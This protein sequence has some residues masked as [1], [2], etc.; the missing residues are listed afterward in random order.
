[1]NNF[2]WTE[3]QDF[4]L[5]RLVA[6]GRKFNVEI[7]KL[8]GK[9]PASITWRIKKLG[10]TPSRQRACAARLGQW[11]AKHSHLRPAAMKYFL[12]HSMAET[13]KRFG[14]TLSEVKSLFTVGYR[15]PELKHLRKD[16]RDHS[17]W[18]TKQLRFLLRHAGL[19]PR[20]WVAEQIGR[21]NQTCIKERLQALGLSSRTLQGITLSQFIQAFGK[22]PSFYLQTDAGPDGGSKTSMPTRWKIVPWVWLDAELKAKRLKTAKEFRML[23]AA[24]AQFQEWIFGGNALAKMKRIVRQAGP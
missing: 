6:D 16:K 22:R 18:T 1:M 14:L 10:L 17:G 12:T 23:V 24:R 7:A 21:G 9:Q 11:N 20:K 5:K 19:R 8:L 4:M 13:Q 2:G 15:M 3:D